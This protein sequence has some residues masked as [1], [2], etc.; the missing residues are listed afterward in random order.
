LLE[1]PES[2]FELSPPAA[3]FLVDLEGTLINFGLSVHSL[4]QS[5]TRFDALASREGICLDRVHYV[6]NASSPGFAP[7]DLLL[8]DLQRVHFR[9]KKPFFNPPKVFVRHADETLV[10]GDEYLTDGLL[11]WRFGF[12]FGFVSSP[13]RQPFWPSLQR[14]V[15]KLLMPLFLVAA[16]HRESSRR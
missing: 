12:L 15:G 3:F 7:Q 6:T 14:L 1:T 10:I 8:P 4:L 11:A 13:Y 16:P 2:A 5:M 9:A